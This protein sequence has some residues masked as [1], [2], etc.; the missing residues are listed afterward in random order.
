M[1]DLILVNSPNQFFTTDSMGNELN[2]DKTYSVG[3]GYVSASLKKEGFDVGFVDGNFQRTPVESIAGEISAQKP[4]AVGM[5]VTLPNLSVVLDTARKIKESYNPLI[6]VGGPGATL[7]HDKIIKDD[8]IDI[9][10]RNEGEET[11]PKLLSG[12]DLQDIPGITYKRNGSV[13]ANPKSEPIKDL[14]SLSFPDTDVIPQEI[15]ELGIVSMFTTRGC[16]NRCTYCSTPEIWDRKIR[17]RSAEGIV[18]EINNYREHFNLKE[19]HFL[20]DTFTVSRKRLYSFLDAYVQAGL[21]KEIGWRCLSRVNTVDED[22]L[23]YMKEA[24][25]NH[26]S[27]GI[28]SANEEVLKDIKKNISPEQAKQVCEMTSRLGIKTKAFFMIGFPGETEKE[29][30]QTLDF[31]ANLDVDRIAINVVKAYPGTALYNEVNQAFPEGYSSDFRCNSSAWEAGDKVGECMKKYAS[32][33]EI[34]CNPHFTPQ[35]LMGFAEEGYRRF[36]ENRGEI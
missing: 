18:D 31:A 35:E 6:I 25:C 19:V 4:A 17:F 12:A 30:N 22:T 20:D 33:P 10:A 14:D 2:T 24:G 5:N 15:K 8:S 21:N 23:D 29:I 11:T 13:I 3:L 26:I 1:K 16:S 27:Y 34:S 28:E 9:V 7:I 36:L 32:I